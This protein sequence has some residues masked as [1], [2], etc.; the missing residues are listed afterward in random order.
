M[1][2]EPHDFSPG[3]RALIAALAASA[4]ALEPGER[5]SVGLATRYLVRALDADD[6]AAV[7]AAAANDDA[8][9]LVLIRVSAVLDDL[10]ARPLGELQSEAL[11][12]GANAEVAA[13]YLETLQVPAE[14]VSEGLAAL[15][16]SGLEGLRLALASLT[17]ASSMRSR[18]TVA[19]LRNAREHIVF[20]NLPGASASIERPA[21]GTGSDLR[22]EGDVG[23]SQLFVAAEFGTCR[24]RIAHGLPTGKRLHLPVEADE[25]RTR[26]V[27]VRANDWPDGSSETAVVFV[28][29]EPFADVKL[30]TVADGHLRIAFDILP[31][32]LPRGKGSLQVSFSLDGSTWQL[33]GTREYGARRPSSD[34]LTLDFPGPDGP[35]RWPLRFV[36]MLSSES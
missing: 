13:A 7:E 12:G 21:E 30:P 34:V 2:S 15:L 11:S 1:P 24:L 14:Q 28:D 5:L 25:L 19:T 6:A 27:F 10:R 36:W 3:A 9:R 4:P 23:E 18:Q 26:R 16:T 8:S 17:A 32:R 35:F 22:L 29:P 31:K 20:E 33:L